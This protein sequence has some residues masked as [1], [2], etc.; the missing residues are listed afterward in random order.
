MRLR[1]MAMSRGLL[2]ALVSTVSLLVPAY[3]ST[4]PVLAARVGSGHD[5]QDSKDKADRERQKRDEKAVQKDL[6]EQQD[7][8]DIRAEIQAFDDVIAVEQL[9]RRHNDPFLQDYITEIG[10]SL[11]P[12]EVPKGVLLSFRVID[13]NP[14]EPRTFA[15]N[16]F[17][18]ADGRIFVTTP[19]L[20]FVQNE[21]QLA[22]VLGH[23]IGH[24]IQQHAVEA[25]KEAH[26]FKRAVLPGLIGG[27]IGAA[28]GGAIKGKEGA[29]VGAVTGAAGGMV[30]SLATMNAYNR[31]Q[32]DEADRI[33]VRLALDRGYDP[34]VGVQLF[35]K[36]ADVFGDDDRL[37]SILWANHSRNADRVNT[38]NRLLDGELAPNYNAGRSA[39]KL[40]VGAGQMLLFASA[41]YRDAALWWMEERD[42]YDIAKPA[43]ESIA[44]YRA[45]DPKTMWALGRLYNVIGR[46]SEDKAKAL[47]YFQRGAQLDERNQYPYVHRDLGLMQARLGPTQMPAAIESLKTYVRGFIDKNTRYPP[48]I[49]QIYDYL[50][51][52]GDSK[53][54]A[55]KMETTLIRASNTEP[56]APVAPDASAKPDTKVTA[57]AKA[58]TPLVKKPIKPG[59]DR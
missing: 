41:M 4:A 20:L 24:V 37:A 25:F 3:G 30:Y 8:K 18:L 27:A 58:V 44:D 22:F 52:F 49:E 46:T 16:A 19:L 34:K 6:K 40:T 12:K 43:L 51:I 28:L 48:D 50:L 45:R 5:D 10:Q 14:D 2:V 26:S 33:G 47:D 55:P 31:K 15:P 38:I 21:A 1:R 7:N 56:A 53:W 42:R 9:Q 29:A 54:T 17:A 36:L 39:G 57:P 59:G 23:E 13:P 11:V 35:Q 32:E